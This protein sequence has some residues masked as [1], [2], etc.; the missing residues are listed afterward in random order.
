LNKQK[1]NIIPINPVIKAL[2]RRKH[3]KIY[4]DPECKEEFRGDFPTNCLQ[5]MMNIENPRPQVFHRTL[6]LKS[7]IPERITDIAFKCEKK[8]LK[9]SWDKN[10]LK[11]NE[12]LCLNIEYYFDGDLKEFRKSYPLYVL[13]RVWS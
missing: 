13:G 2:K 9:L 1:K 4:T 10:E 8:G 3:F 6:Y 11:E 5:F 7:I 12:I